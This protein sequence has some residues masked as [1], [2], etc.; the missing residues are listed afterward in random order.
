MEN[1]QNLETMLDQLIVANPQIFDILGPTLYTFNGHSVPRVTKIIEGCNYDRGLMEWSNGLGWRRQSFSEVMKRAANIGTQTHE[2]INNH[3]NGTESIP[4]MDEA[5]YA[6]LSYV[7]WFNDISA[8]NQVRI[9]MNEQTLVC[10]YFG[11]T[12]DGLYEINGRLFVVDYKTSNHVTYKYFLQLAAYAYMLEKMGYAI[13]GCI[14]VQLCKSEATYN[15]FLLDLNR[16]DAKWYFENCKIGFLSMVL[17]YYHKC[18]I[19]ENYNTVVVGE[20][21]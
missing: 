6:Y 13:S 7:R 16:E 19:A 2:S 15:E 12:I 1:L 3:I 17:W 20:H 5:R 14:I 18:L 21:K 10:S 9:V 4:E 11:G 8:A